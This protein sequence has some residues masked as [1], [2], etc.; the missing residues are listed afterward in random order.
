MNAMLNSP[1]L[2]SN[3]G[4][5]GILKIVFL[6]PLNANLIMVDV[7]KICEISQSYEE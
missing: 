7:D 6:L 4:D 3:N 5:N 2:E 1:S